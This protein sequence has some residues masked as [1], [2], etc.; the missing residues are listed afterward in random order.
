MSSARSPH[1]IGN[2]E[3]IASLVEAFE[4]RALAETELN[5]PAPRMHE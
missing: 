1:D 2:R 3:D 5:P 4:Y